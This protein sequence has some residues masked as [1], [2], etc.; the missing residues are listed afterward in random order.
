M[1][2]DSGK[3]DTWREATAKETKDYLAGNLNS[4]LKPP[5]SRKI[6]K[7]TSFLHTYYSDPRQ[8]CCP[9]QLLIALGF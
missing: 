2:Y 1:G 9:Q 3:G 8:I 4:K 6:R 7:G 5:D